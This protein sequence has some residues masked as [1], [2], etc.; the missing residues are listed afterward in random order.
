MSGV[1][2]LDSVLSIGQFHQVLWGGETRYAIK[3]ENI[4]ETTKLCSRLRGQFNIR[5]Y[6]RLFFKKAKIRKN[7]SLDFFFFVT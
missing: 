4:V 5:N 7:V 2:R 1:L 6:L 3:L